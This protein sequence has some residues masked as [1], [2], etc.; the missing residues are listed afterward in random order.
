MAQ[1]KWQAKAPGKLDLYKEHAAEYLA[2]KTPT[3]VEIGRAHYLAI[4]GQGP[5][6]DDGFG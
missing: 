1:G 3:L 4:A 2:P 6:G 5:P